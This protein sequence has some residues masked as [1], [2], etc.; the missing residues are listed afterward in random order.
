M[1]G[2]RAA[3]WSLLLSARFINTVS[4]KHLHMP[5]SVAGHDTLA[6]RPIDWRRPANHSESFALIGGKVSLPLRLP[7]VFICRRCFEVE[8]A[9]SVGGD[10]AGLTALSVQAVS[11][12]L[13]S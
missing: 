5:S 10:N 3:V 11:P 6:H 9:L 13:S 2:N 8:S 7:K 1:H 4:W 12:D